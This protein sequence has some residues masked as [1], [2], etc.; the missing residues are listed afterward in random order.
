MRYAL[1]FALLPLLI[2]GTGFAG[3]GARAAQ[4]RVADPRLAIDLFAESPQIVTPIGL[5]VDAKGRVLA[6]ESNTHFRPPN[7]KGPATD[8]IRMF[9]DTKSTGR[10]DRV[11]TWFEGTSSTMN[12]AVYRDGSV[13][14]ATRNEIF[15]LRDSKQSGVADERTPIAHLET[16]G[17]YPH[18]GLSGFAFDFHGDVYFGIGENLGA[19]YKLVGSDASSISGGGEGGNIFRCRPDGSHLER[20]ATGFWNPFH[21]CFTAFGRLMAVDNDPDSR[22]PCRL[23]E[24]VPGGDY[25]FRFR[26]GR[27]GLHPFVAWNGELP[28]TLPMA[29]ATGEAPAG[30]VAYE[31]DGL[32]ADYRGELFATSWGDHRIDRFTLTAH[33]ATVWAKMTPLVTGGD[34][35]RPVSIAVAPDGSLFVSDWVDKSYSVHGKGRIWHIHAVNPPSQ[36]AHGIDSEPR[37]VREAAAR[38]MAANLTPSKQTPR[39]LSVHEPDDRVRAAAIEALADANDA[40]TDYMAVA[41][42]DRSTEVRALAVRCMPITALKPHLAA[43]IKPSQ[44]AAVRAEAL[45]RDSDP[46][47]RDAALATLDDPDPFLQQ[48]ARQALGQMPDA[49]EGIDPAKLPTAAQRLG[50]M[51]V[52]RRVDEPAGRKFL[53]QFLDDPDTAIRFAAIEWAGEERIK[54]VR[55]KIVEMLSARA[56]TRELFEACVAA[57]EL[58]DGTQRPDEFHGEEYVVRVLNDAHASN[59]MR[60]LALRMLRPDHPALTM[61]LIKG[62][63]AS[64][65]EGLRAEAIRSLRDSL[66]GGRIDLLAEEAGDAHSPA[67]LRAEA[68]VG[69]SDAPQQRDFLLSLAAADEPAVRNEALRSLRGAPL[70]ATQRERLVALSHKDSAAADLV[71]MILNPPAAANPPR[72]DV[73]A[74]LKQLDGPADPQAGERIFFHPRAA[75]CFRCHQ[76]HG[77]GGHVGPD[78]S[79]DARLLGR[80][81]LVESIVDPSKEIA[82]RFIPWRLVTKDGRSL[83]GL[84]VTEGP[85]DLETYSDSAGKLFVLDPAKIAE[86]HPLTTSIMPEGLANLLTRQEF[87]DLLAFLL[88]EEHK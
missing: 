27:S 9:E 47:T 42:D 39:L 73:D 50:W 36:P 26:Y 80:R 54:D 87:R 33:G 38:R 53:P 59:T 67:S 1:R 31:S 69:L 75:G 23:L 37:E 34:D 4:P 8:R 22:P 52:M 77:R 56:D 76:I 66:V 5:T 32:P 46:A 71:T 24:V 49:I 17:N 10:A 61:T 64:A 60:Q 6:V 2:T 3:R 35:F 57:L 55:P 11:S 25:G 70:S 79:T 85:G 40:N 15:R 62:F 68:I 16:K 82:P 44:P 78:L 88:Q 7:Y 45:R 21:L 51:L 43:L 13:Y 30:I 20:V 58:L 14:V 28:G 72:H 29:S 48:A 19:A 63:L 74:W 18:N 83:T 41:F 12:L 84:L 65:D 86:R 81:K